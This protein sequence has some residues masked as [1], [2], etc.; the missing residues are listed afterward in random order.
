MTLFSEACPSSP[1]QTLPLLPRG[2]HPPSFKTCESRP[3][4][5]TFLQ[6]KE[7]LLSWPLLF[8]PCCGLLHSLELIHGVWSC[9]IAGLRLFLAR[10]FCS[11]PV[12]ALA[13][14]GWLFFLSAADIH[15]TQYGGSCMEKTELKPVV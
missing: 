8:L 3:S 6:G 5:V 1:L 4:P 9:E 14:W 7:L 2:Q 12:D 10:N 13:D 11:L 15:H